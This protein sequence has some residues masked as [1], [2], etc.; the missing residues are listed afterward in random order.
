[1]QL[2][3][4][5]VFYWSPTLFNLWALLLHEAKDVSEFLWEED[6]RS[7]SWLLYICQQTY[8]ECQGQHI[9][10]PSDSKSIQIYT[11]LALTAEVQASATQDR[12][13]GWACAATHW[14]GP[15][16]YSHQDTELNFSDSLNRC[17]LAEIDQP[18][19]PSSFCRWHPFILSSHFQTVLHVRGDPRHCLR[20][21]PLS[22]ILRDP[23]QST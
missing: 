15:N 12:K 19:F 6:N 11:A 10:P 1:M 8:S 9:E 13:P 23:R 5:I 21:R 3:I 14:S 7:S 16:V 4:G 17:T 18:C 2:T 22:K 20:H